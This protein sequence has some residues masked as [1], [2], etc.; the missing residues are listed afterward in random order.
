MRTGRIAMLRG[1]KMLKGV[2]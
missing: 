1:S 2:K